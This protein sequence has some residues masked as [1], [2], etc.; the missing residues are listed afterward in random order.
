MKNMSTAVKAPSNVGDSKFWT[1]ILNFLYTGV[2]EVIQFVHPV[3]NRYYSSNTQTAS[4]KSNPSSVPQSI[5]VTVVE[6]IP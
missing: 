6:G 5:V 4:H 2:M 3:Q 1:C